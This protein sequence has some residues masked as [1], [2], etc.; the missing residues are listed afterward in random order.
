MNSRSPLR[1]ALLVAA[2]FVFGGCAYAQGRG[3]KGGTTTSRS[4]RRFPRTEVGATQ[5][6]DMARVMESVRSSLVKK[7]ITRRD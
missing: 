7:G 6:M 1:F 5:L 4:G 2:L 3:L